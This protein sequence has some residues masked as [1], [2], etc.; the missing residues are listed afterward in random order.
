MLPNAYDVF[1][2]HSHCDRDWATRLRDRLEAQGIKVWMDVDEIEPGARWVGTLEDGLEHSG[3]VAVICTTAALASDWV[4]EEC[5]RAIDLKKRLIP[6]LKDD[7]QITGFLANRQFVD[8]RGEGDQA[9]ARLVWGITGER[10]RAEPSSARPGDRASNTTTPVVASDVVSALK[11]LPVWGLD[12]HVV[13]R[14]GGIAVEA[15]RSFCIE[16]RVFR[17]TWHGAGKRQRQHRLGA[18]EKGFLARE[19]P[20]LDAG[21]HEPVKEARAVPLKLQFRTGER[22]ALVGDAGDGKT[23]ALWLAVHDHVSE[24]VRRAAAE[25]GWLDDAGAR[26]PLVLPLSVLRDRDSQDVIKTAFAYTAN[27]VSPNSDHRH[28]GFA[29]W[30]SEKVRRGEFSLFIDGLDEISSERRAAL[31]S[32]LARYRDLPML[33][34]A[35]PTVDPRE[36]RIGFRSWRL[37]PLTARDIRRYVAKHRASALES[38]GR[39]VELLEAPHARRFARSPLLL[40]LLCEHAELHPEEDLPRTRT[41]LVDFAVQAMLRRGD[42]RRDRPEDAR[43][44][45]AKISLLSHIAWRFYGAGPL[46]IPKSLLLDAILEWD[47]SQGRAAERLDLSEE[48]L[49][50]EIVQD[51]ILVPAGGRGQLRF[52]LRSLHEWFLARH[53]ASEH[54]DAKLPRLIRGRAWRWGRAEWGSIKPLNQPEWRAVWPYLAGHLGDKAHLLLDALLYECRRHEDVGRGRILLTGL[55]AAEAPDDV[56]RQ[57][58]I[59][60]ALVASLPKEGELFELLGQLAFPD[61]RDALLKMWN[62]DPEDFSGCVSW[63]RAIAECDPGVARE[64]LVSRLRSGVLRQNLYLREPYAIALGEVADEHTV[65]ALILDLEK[66]T[67]PSPEARAFARVHSVSMRALAET[68][69]ARARS[70]LW[71]VFA[72]EFSGKPLLGE[73]TARAIGLVADDA[74]RDQLLDLL[75]LPDLPPW[76]LFLLSH[77]LATIGDLQSRDALFALMKRPGLKPGQRFACAVSLGELGDERARPWLIRGLRRHLSSL[78]GEEHASHPLK[79]IHDACVATA[80]GA[81]EQELILGL[82]NRDLAYDVRWDIAEILSSIGTPRGKRALVEEL[83][84]R[85]SGSRIAFACSSLL[86]HE[87]DDETRNA[88]LRFLEGQPR[89]VRLSTE[90]W[91]ALQNLMSDSS[92]R[93]QAWKAIEGV[94]LS[95]RD[96]RLLAD[97][98]AM[99]PAAMRR[100]LMRGFRRGEQSPREFREYQKSTGWRLVRPS[101]RRMWF[102]LFVAY[103]GFL[104]SG[105]FLSRAWRYVLYVVLLAGALKL[106]GLRWEKP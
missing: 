92:Y 51:G 87:R 24:I 70:A 101:P 14:P 91:A 37:A 10:P 26:P 34:T 103:M 68:E 8:L 55:V 67:T 33:A 12:R 18:T 31:R 28:E 62:D 96:R 16:P 90:S 39:H 32:E 19:A 46:P 97:L 9:F 41:A 61:A 66:I 38:S 44:D 64:T 82:K 104:A 6:I 13:S 58:G 17:Q 94:P 27:L 75:Q 29:A 80:T 21:S 95:R 72:K 73:E 74:L 57:C 106:G 2:S 99:G 25:P 77:A 53:V 71:R 48:A 50:K 98:G 60:E 1:L 78:V 52:V 76:Q 22:I 88:L 89:D 40:A 5:Y 102:C 49:L 36:L 47:G 56:K 20:W 86:I 83:A 59:V 100:A 84:E 81:L 3:A 54:N 23:T 85:N 35:R 42:A 65:D 11:L 30:L 69:S 93:S 79:W 63:V 105:A 45:A 7:V 4:K 15:L 43:I